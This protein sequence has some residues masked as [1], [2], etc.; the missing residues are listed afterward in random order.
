MNIHTNFKSIWKIVLSAFV[1]ALVLFSFF[2]VTGFRK[3]DGFTVVRVG[4]I[5]LTHIDE[6]T[7][8]FINNKL[9][10]GR[11]KNDGTRTLRNLFPGEYSI[12][13]VREGYWPWLK[14]I[15]VPEKVKV[16]IAPFGVLS[17][18]SGVIIPTKDEDYDTIANKVRSEKLPTDKNPT[19]SNDDNAVVWVE[20][21]ALLVR[22]IGD[23]QTPPDSFCR[24]KELCTGTTTVFQTS[25]IIRSVDFFKGRN[26]VVI[27]ATLDGVFAIEVDTRGTQNF[28]PIIKGTSLPIF[29]SKDIDSLYVLDGEFLYLVNL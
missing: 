22:W 25:S 15:N 2:Y 5:V 19:L 12:L 17:N 6:E 9:K 14:E 20:G 1:F 29:S 27:V 13:V 18:I 16:K 3:G 11:T 28:Q 24:D 23:T 21:N 4:S 7:Q 8:V 26:D 10:R